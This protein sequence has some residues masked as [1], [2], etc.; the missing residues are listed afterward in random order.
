[1]ISFKDFC[2]N[3]AVNEMHESNKLNEGLYDGDTIKDEEYEKVFTGAETNIKDKKDDNNFV[4]KSNS[5][6]GAAIIKVSGIAGQ[7]IKDSKTGKL[8]LFL[9]NRNFTPNSFVAMNLDNSE[10]TKMSDYKIVSSE[11]GL[12]KVNNI[13][14]AAIEA[15]F[16]KEGDACYINIVW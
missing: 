16:V 14:K 7:N 6:S 13:Y 4:E 11:K 8:C 5:K 9:L 1:M 15:N 10:S 3:H 12:E 2:K